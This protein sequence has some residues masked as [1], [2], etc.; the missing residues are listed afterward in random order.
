MINKTTRHFI[1]TRKVG[2]EKDDNITFFLYVM[3]GICRLVPVDPRP[4]AEA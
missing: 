1:K 2:I 4:H 3:E